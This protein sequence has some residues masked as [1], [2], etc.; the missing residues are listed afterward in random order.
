MLLMLLFVSLVNVKRTTFLIMEYVQIRFH[1]E[2]KRFHNDNFSK[3]NT[4]VQYILSWN[5]PK[6]L[7]T[8]ISFHLVLNLEVIILVYI[9]LLEITFKLSNDYCWN[10]KHLFHQEN[11]FKQLPTTLKKVLNAHYRWRHHKMP[12]SS[13]PVG[14]TPVG[15]VQLSS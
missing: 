9:L 4:S 2:A 3:C 1:F 7:N 13:V 6:M 8:M 5:K 12:R 10:F 14:Y 15:A 11:Y